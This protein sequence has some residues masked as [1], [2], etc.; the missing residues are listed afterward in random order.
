MAEGRWSLGCTPARGSGSQSC[1]PWVPPW[2]TAKPEVGA[3][4]RTDPG[5]SRR[6]WQ[7]VAQGSLVRRLCPCPWP[8]C[9][10]TPSAPRQVSHC[11]LPRIP[12]PALVSA[13]VLCAP[14][15]AFPRAGPFCGDAGDA[16]VPGEPEDPEDAGD[17]GDLGDVGDAG[18]PPHACRIRGCV[19]SLS[20]LFLAVSHDHST[21]LVWLRH[22]FPG[23]W[24]R[25]EA[26]GC[27]RAAFP[28][29]IPQQFLAVIQPD[30][31][32][33][34]QHPAVL[35]PVSPPPCC[36]RTHSPRFP[37][38]SY[39]S[40]S[41]SRAGIPGTSGGA[42]LCAPLSA[43]RTRN[44]CPGL[45]P[46]GKCQAMVG[47][48][49]PVP[50]LCCSQAQVAG[51]AA[52]G[53]GAAAWGGPEM[54]HPLCP[55]AVGA[56]GGGAR[57]VPIRATPGRERSGNA[58][59]MQQTPGTSGLGI[60][61]HPWGAQHAPSPIWGA[62]LMGP[63]VLAMRTLLAGSAWLLLG[64]TAPRRSADGGAQGEVHFGWQSPHPGAPLAKPRCRAASSWVLA[65]RLP[66]VPSLAEAAGRF[67]CGSSGELPKFPARRGRNS[68]ASSPQH[69]PPC[70]H[71]SPPVAPCLR[72]SHR[73][74]G[75]A[76]LGGLRHD[77]GLCRDEEGSHDVGR[78][79]AP[80]RGPGEALG[81]PA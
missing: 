78:S 14:L 81:A 19:P 70:P 69:V 71:G 72:V 8:T 53:A 33:V 58:V 48:D 10:G 3:G 80:R 23:W 26:H 13:M 1:P 15:P 46:L 62:G 9:S 39:S 75:P 73:A 25:S 40:A 77:R 59:G 68:P 29:L 76:V 56:A 32:A 36:Q 38:C 16:Q 42:L 22:S 51:G 45:Q 79:A 61:P 7:S 5:H 6:P 65:G 54:E 30:S 74:G 52:E 66:P 37:P 2:G 63:G 27:V 43:T 57:F 47:L 20:Q 35:L 4:G 11:C 31:I 24:H 41:G 64:P 60:L 34:P 28:R 17:P 44:L 21:E 55:P 49:I 50:Q 67:P 12:Q 18:D